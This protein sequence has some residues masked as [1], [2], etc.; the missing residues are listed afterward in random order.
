VPVAS[1]RP[2][3]RTSAGGGLADCGQDCEVCFWGTF[4]SL[5]LYGQIKARTGRAPDCWSGCMELTAV[6]I[7]TAIV[8][9]V[10]AVRMLANTAPY[11]ETYEE[12]LQNAQAVQHL[13]QFLAC[14]SQP[15][16]TLV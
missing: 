2:A 9:Q 3:C 14:V 13:C 10:F 8:G 7:G 15:L 12:N 6:Q 1:P 16:W 11:A 4:C 5:C